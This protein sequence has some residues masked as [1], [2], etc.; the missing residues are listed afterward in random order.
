[1]IRKY[2][3]REERIELKGIFHGKAITNPSGDTRK[4]LARDEFMFYTLSVTF[5]SPVPY[6]E[7][8]LSKALKATN[9]NYSFCTK[10][11]KRGKVLF[12]KTA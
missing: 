10:H 1:M 12:E 11:R 6:I 9:Y 5:V 8:R 4:N 2:C 3:S 7:I